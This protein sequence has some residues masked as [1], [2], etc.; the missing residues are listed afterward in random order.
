M[1]RRQLGSNFEAFLA[2][3]GILEE[4]RALAIE[5]K[6]ERFKTAQEKPRVGVVSKPTRARF[7]RSDGKR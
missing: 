1:K 2:A 5:F 6:V 7:G 4:C 3:D